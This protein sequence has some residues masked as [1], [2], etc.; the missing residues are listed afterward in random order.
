[1]SV[2]EHVIEMRSA[3][4]CSS[5]RMTGESVV[6]RQVRVVVLMLRHFDVC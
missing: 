4:A 1:V 6:V 3:Q 2:G 5:G